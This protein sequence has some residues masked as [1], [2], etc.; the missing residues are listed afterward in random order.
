MRGEDGLTDGP[1]APPGTCP[2]CGAPVGVRDSFC[3]ACGTELTPPGYAD[4]MT[5][6]CLRA[7]G[8]DARQIAAVM[9]HPLPSIGG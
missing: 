3:E 8:T 7:F 6:L 9:K 1:L 5:E 2:S 4:Q